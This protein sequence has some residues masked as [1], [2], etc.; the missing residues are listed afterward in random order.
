MKEEIVTY[1]FFGKIY[2]M[3]NKP[4]R[5]LFIFIINVMTTLIDNMFI[6]VNLIH[7]QTK[8]AI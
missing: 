2:I 3:H 1:M 4:Y 6:Y 5:N 7:M 8:H